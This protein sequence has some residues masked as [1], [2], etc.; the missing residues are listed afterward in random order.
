MPPDHVQLGIKGE[1]KVGCHGN[2]TV[3]LVNFNEKP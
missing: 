2:E 1:K 3:T